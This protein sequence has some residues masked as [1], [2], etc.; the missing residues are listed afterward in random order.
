MRNPVQFSKTLISMQYVELTDVDLQIPGPKT[1]KVV[2]AE[3]QIIHTRNGESRI[4][5]IFETEA[6]ADAHMDET[7]R[8]AQ[9]D[10]ELMRELTRK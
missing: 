4:H 7:L 8:Q 6:D 1:G 5:M 9:I 2:G 3:W 10:A